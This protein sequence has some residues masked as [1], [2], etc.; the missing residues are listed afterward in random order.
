MRRRRGSLCT[1]WTAQLQ[2]C[3]VGCGAILIVE[4][5]AQLGGQRC[6]RVGRR[7]AYPMASGGLRLP[8]QLSVDR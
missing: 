7:F 8:G 5:A 6:A 4:I 2:A 1:E 3:T